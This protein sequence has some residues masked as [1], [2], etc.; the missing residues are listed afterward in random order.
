MK[1]TI[2]FKIIYFLMQLLPY[3]M[4]SGLIRILYWSKLLL[5]W[6]PF[7]M[8]YYFGLTLNENFL[9]NFV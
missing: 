2:N 5:S 9:I 6:T 7:V 8:R 3:D 1:V 4:Y